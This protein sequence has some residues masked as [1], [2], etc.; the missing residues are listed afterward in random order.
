MVSI[1]RGR[2]EGDLVKLSRTDFRRK[3]KSAPH[4]LLLMFPSLGHWERELPS[5]MLGSRGVT[6]GGLGNCWCGG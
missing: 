6:G 1:A 4:H 2:S 3:R 5:H